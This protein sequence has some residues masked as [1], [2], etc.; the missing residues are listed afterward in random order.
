MSSI[1]DE[2]PIS[3][4]A[5]PS[6]GGSGGS[7]GNGGSR[8]KKKS[9]CPFGDCKYRMKMTDSIIVCRCGT[10]FCPSHRLPEQHSCVFN[11]RAAAMQHLSSQLVKCAGD[12]LMDKL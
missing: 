9:C 3:A 1:S 5:V 12:R 7:G 8:E 2:S 10:S 4:A 11:Y 6:G